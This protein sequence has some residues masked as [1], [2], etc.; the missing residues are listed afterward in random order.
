MKTYNNSWYPAKNFTKSEIQ[1]DWMVGVT[2]FSTFKDSLYGT[3]IKK[4]ETVLWNR[5][6]KNA[7]I[8][9]ESYNRAIST[10]DD[11]ALEKIKSLG[12]PTDIKL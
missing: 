6:L 7:T 1:K 11:V 8:T 5:S 3:P 4:F 2:H 9:L 10:K 12:L